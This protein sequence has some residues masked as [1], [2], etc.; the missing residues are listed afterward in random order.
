MPIAERKENNKTCSAGKSKISLCMVEEGMF[1]CLICPVALRYKEEVSW[2]RNLERILIGS[3]RLSVGHFEGNQC[4]SNFSSLFLWNISTDNI[5][6]T[7][8]C[9]KTK[10]P[11]YSLGKYILKAKGK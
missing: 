5:G 7:Y 1:V 4:H 3:S 2:S 10:N 6:E 9:F 11:E 8:T